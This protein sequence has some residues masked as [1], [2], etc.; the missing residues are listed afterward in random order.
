MLHAHPAIQGLA[1]PHLVHP[2]MALRPYATHPSPD[3]RARR[4]LEAF[5]QGLPDGE[6]VQLRAIRAYLNELYAAALGAAPQGTRW[7]V[8][9]TPA[10][11]RAVRFIRELY[12]TAPLII[13]RR[14]P[15]AI[16]WSHARTFFGGDLARARQE[17]PILSETIPALAPVLRG[18]LGS[19]HV[20][21]YE[22]LVAQPRTELRRAFEAL[23]LSDHPGAVNYGA[24]PL[25]GPGDPIE[26]DKHE[27]PVAELAEKWRPVFTESPEL[28]AEVEMQL[29][30]ISDRDLQAWGWPREHLWS[31]LEGVLAE[32]ARP[33]LDS[34]AMSRGALL[35]LR[36][37]IHQRPHGRIVLRI[38]DICDLLLR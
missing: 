10:N 2:L 25:S 13:L 1:E 24:V 37:D 35:W 12:P 23:G 19:H 17:R 26:L 16:A 15:A 8:D 28:R 20:V 30:R 4:G 33:M 14:H 38:R 5:L 27:R 21:D 9:K 18:E 36:K 29:E 22:K 31:P 34:Y 7:L 3:L 6:D 32:A 11:A